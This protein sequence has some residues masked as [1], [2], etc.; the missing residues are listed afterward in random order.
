M[1]TIE[2]SAA[3]ASTP[4]QENLKN[5]A[6]LDAQNALGLMTPERLAAV[7]GDFLLD[8]VKILYHNKS[9][10]DFPYCAEIKSWSALEAQGHIASG[11]LLIQGDRHLV[12]APTEAAEPLAWST[13]AVSGGGTTTSDRLVAFSDW[14]GKESTKKQVSHAECNTETLAPG[15][16]N[17]YARPNANGK[18][19]IAG[20]WW[21]PSVAEMMLIYANKKKINAALSVIKGASKLTEGWYW[22]STESSATGAWL[23]NLSNGYVNRWNDKVKGKY[24]VRA[25]SAFIV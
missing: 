24:R 10:S 19:L 14:N 2:L 3:L 22:T 5:F 11:V 20:K 25:V 4:V 15:F 1:K 18:G 23:F 16:C 13:A 8:G 17:R 12:I 6:G 21:L 9:D 7:A